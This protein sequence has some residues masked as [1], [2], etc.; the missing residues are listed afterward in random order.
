MHMPLRAMS[1]AGV[2][3]RRFADCVCRRRFVALLVCFFSRAGCAL[4]VMQ[5]GKLV[6]HPSLAPACMRVLHVHVSVASTAPSP[7]RVSLQ[8][9]RGGEAPTCGYDNASFWTRCSETSMS[10]ARLE[11]H[12]GGT[13]R[14][15][16]AAAPAG[17]LRGRIAGSMLREAGGGVSQLQP[18]SHCLPQQ[19]GRLTVLKSTHLC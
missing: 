2:R 6:D 15:S 4:C 1:E 9:K 13:D 7:E 19:R 17:E 18:A 8:G 14:G 16:A 11:M 5:V 3:S 12:S 10:S